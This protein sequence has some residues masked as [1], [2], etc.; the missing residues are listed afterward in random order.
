MNE[1]A[2]SCCATGGLFGHLAHSEFAVEQDV[3]S[4]GNFYTLRTCWWA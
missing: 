3:Q 2:Q 4:L 1:I